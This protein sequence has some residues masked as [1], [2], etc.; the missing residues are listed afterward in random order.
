MAPAFS[1]DITTTDTTTSNQTILPPKWTD[2]CD[3]GYENA[4]YKNN[5]DIF[6][7]LSFVKDERT[8]RNYWAQRRESFE[9]YLK[10]CNAL[11]DEAKGTCY[12]ELR[13]VETQK[14]EMYKIKRRQIIQVNDIRNDI[15]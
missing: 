12:Q 8:K 7:L 1:N 3:I 10:S 15:Q 6:N 13:N 4:V 11:D 14:N 9:K 5:N 2:F